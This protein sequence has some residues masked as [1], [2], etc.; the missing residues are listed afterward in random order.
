VSANFKPK[1]IHVPTYYGNSNMPKEEYDEPN[2]PVMFAN[3]A[4]ARL[5]LGTDDPTNMVVPDIQAERRPGGW[6]VFI[7]LEGDTQAVVYFL[8][9]DTTVYIMPETLAT[10]EVIKSERSLPEEFDKTSPAP[11]ENRQSR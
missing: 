1:V 3:V 7:N 11:L 2:V 10:V 4:G 5:L 8:D 6:A 9:N